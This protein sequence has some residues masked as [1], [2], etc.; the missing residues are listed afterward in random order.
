M[1]ACVCVCVCVCLCVCVCVSVC[2]QM[3]E[4]E[5]EETRD[6]KC[7]VIQKRLCDF[8]HEIYQGHNWC[9]NGNFVCVTCRSCMVTKCWQPA[10]WCWP[11]LSPFDSSSLSV[12]MLSPLSPLEATACF[13]FSS[14]RWPLCEK[15]LPLCLG[16]AQSGGGRCARK[17][18]ILGGRGMEWAMFKA[19]YLFFLKIDFGRMK[20]NLCWIEIY[21]TDAI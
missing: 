16:G 8:P 18:K 7:R 10:A 1:K 9:C 21:L 19:F 2:V 12:A 13:F 14:G 3:S 20:W 11:T 17:W 15:T 4:L 5:R 6:K